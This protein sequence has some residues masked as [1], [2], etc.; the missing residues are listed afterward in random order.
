MKSRTY[1]RAKI[2]SVP[3]CYNSSK[4]AL[5]AAISYSPKSLKFASS[6][7]SDSGDEI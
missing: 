5:S 6:D 4:S 2:I 1:G 3:N 7:D